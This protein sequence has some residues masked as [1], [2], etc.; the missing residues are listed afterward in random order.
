MTRGVYGGKATAVIALA[1]SPGVVWVRARAMAPA[2]TAGRAPGEVERIELDLAAGCSASTS[3]RGT[4][5]PKKAC[6]WKTPG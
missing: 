4:S 2:D 5:K 1:R 6:G 3:S